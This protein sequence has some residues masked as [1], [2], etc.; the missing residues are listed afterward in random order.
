MFR[1]KCV[2][3][4]LL[5]LLSF[6]NT[7]TQAQ[8]VGYVGGGWGSSD[9]DVSGYDNA[10]SYKIYFGTQFSRN[11]ALELA[12]TYLGKFYYDVSNGG[13]NE[14]DGYEL[15]LVG[16]YPVSD[17][18]SLLA[19]A[20]AYA[21]NVD[22]RWQGTRLATDSDTNLTYGVG[23]RAGLSDNLSFQLDYQKYDDVSGGNF[24][25]VFGSLAY[26]F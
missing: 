1:K 7:V 4:F 26:K 14:T 8:P 5:Y 3:L 22:V 24:D 23:L 25:S 20:G 21:W 13:Y 18:I 12:Y 17:S 16:V 2:L 10:S 15:T 9:V 19:R 11:A 6:G